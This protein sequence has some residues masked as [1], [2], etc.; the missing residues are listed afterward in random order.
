MSTTNFQSITHQVSP[1]LRVAYEH[2]PSPSLQEIRREM[3]EVRV[4]ETT[5]YALRL[6][7]AVAVVRLFIA[8]YRVASFEEI[9]ARI[10]SA[11]FES[12]LSSSTHDAYVDE[13]A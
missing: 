8:N 4:K 1:S 5:A 3:V 6:E 12:H 9:L 7:G 2:F 13:N 10:Y 11:F